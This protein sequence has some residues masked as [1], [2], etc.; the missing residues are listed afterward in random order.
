MIR[1]VRNNKSGQMLLVRN[2][3]VDLEFDDAEGEEEE[4][5][6][7]TGEAA[8]SNPPS[9][10]GGDS[11]PVQAELLNYLADKRI[12]SPNMVLLECKECHRAN[13]NKLLW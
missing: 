1:W 8:A 7:T 11:T 3:N 9:K 12:G 4:S 5:G 6:P 13:N 2:K 10:A